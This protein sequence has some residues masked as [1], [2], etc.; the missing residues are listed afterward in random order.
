MPAYNDANFR[1]LFPAFS[2]ETTYPAATLSFY[3]T[4][5]TDYINPVGKSWNNLNGA[6]LQL[7]I[8]SLC[9]HLTTLFTTDANNVADGD[10]PGENIGITVSASIGN[11]SVTDLPPPSADTWEWWLNQTS[12]G[13]N[14]L[15]LLKLKAVGG[16]YVGGLPEREGFRKAGGVF[17]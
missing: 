13:T 16:F 4:V 5:A 17:W 15:A 11:V 3:W 6:S 2:N 12:Y 10:A 1:Q 7:A 8:D 14:L 9:A